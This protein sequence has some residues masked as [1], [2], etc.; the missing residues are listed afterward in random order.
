MS[1]VRYDALST[2]RLRHGQEDAAAAMEF[3]RRYGVSRSVW[4]L[5]PPYEG[6]PPRRRVTGLRLLIGGAR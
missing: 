6:R 4:Q 2:W 3:E 1:A 5:L